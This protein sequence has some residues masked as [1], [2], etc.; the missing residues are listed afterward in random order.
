MSEE[1]VSQD[2]SL[3]KKKK[4]SGNG[5]S[6]K[7]REQSEYPAFSESMEHIITT[8][9]PLRLAYIQAFA[10]PSQFPRIAAYT[11]VGRP[12]PNSN[13]LF[14]ACPPT[15]LGWLYDN[16]SDPNVVKLMDD[17][18]YTQAVQASTGLMGLLQV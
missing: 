2:A 18:T 15:Y 1:L 13:N 5:S 7:E 17:A 10:N 16:L 4:K 11:V 14:G 12:I 6:Y 9:L 3:E 8:A